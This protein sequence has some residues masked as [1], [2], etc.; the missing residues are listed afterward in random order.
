[1]L[2]ESVWMNTLS[3]AIT[4]TEYDVLDLI[5]MSVLSLKPNI[6]AAP[7]LPV[8]ND[9]WSA[10][11]CICDSFPSLNLIPAFAFIDRSSLDAPLLS[12]S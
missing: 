2:F 4:P 10:V 3:G 11:S 8:V 7:W 6:A 5:P 12:L 9:N 1:M